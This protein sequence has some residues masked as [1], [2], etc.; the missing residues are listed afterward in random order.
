MFIMELSYNL[1]NWSNLYT[2]T[3]VGEETS[4]NNLKI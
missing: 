3:H 4:N 2:H 1:N